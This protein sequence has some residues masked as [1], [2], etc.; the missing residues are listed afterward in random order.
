MTKSVIFYLPEGFADWEGAF[1]LAELREANRPVKIVTENGQPV[2]S[3][4]G[5]KVHVE[6]ALTEIT[7][8][9]TAALVLIGSDSW[10]KLE[11]NQKALAIAKDFYERGILVAGICAATTALARVG[12]LGSEKHTSNSLQQLKYFVPAYGGEKFYVEAPAVT[13]GNLI[14]ASGIAPLEFTR[15]IL[16]QLEVYSE[17]KRLQWYEMYKNG[18]QPPENYWS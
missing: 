15:E 16:N 9:E 3:F 11:K 5:M 8:D 7:P 14:T 17:A 18:V 6:Q 13:D 2:T 1:L 12:L 4:G 10:P